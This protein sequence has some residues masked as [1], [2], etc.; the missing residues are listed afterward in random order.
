[1]GSAGRTEKSVI[2]E[3]AAVILRTSLA[4]DHSSYHLA[5]FADGSL[6]NRMVSSAI[7]T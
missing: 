7:L 2:Q 1:M 6:S 4:H 3:E 5:P